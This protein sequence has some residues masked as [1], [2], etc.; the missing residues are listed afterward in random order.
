MAKL[1][2]VMVTPE[3]QVLRSEA[4]QVIAPSVFGEVGI[5]P[6]HRPLVAALAEG[7]LTLEQGST[8]RVFAVSGGFLEVRQNEVTI[9]AETAEQKE[10]IDIGRA[11]KA[12]KEAE[13]KIATLDASD[14]HYIEQRARL[15]RAEVRLAVTGK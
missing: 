12:V 4:D 14:P 9:L 1:H 5:L 11:K 10:D 3:R 6:D 7:V 8:N 15:R 13:N 2:V